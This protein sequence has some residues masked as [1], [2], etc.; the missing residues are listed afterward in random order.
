[1]FHTHMFV[2]Y[3]YS[4]LT[5][6]P[7]TRGTNDNELQTLQIPQQSSTLWHGFGLHSYK[8]DNSLRP[9]K[10][11]HMRPR[12]QLTEAQSHRSI[13]PKFVTPTAPPCIDRAV[14]VTNLGVML[15]CTEHNFRIQ[16]QPSRALT[17]YTLMAQVKSTH[18]NS[19]ILAE[20]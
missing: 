17:Q 1:M 5:K 2:N 18:I 8:M 6:G 19:L 10:L 12:G 13:T 15:L 11:H 14:R 3:S 4:A 9:S 16:N 20:H 7:G